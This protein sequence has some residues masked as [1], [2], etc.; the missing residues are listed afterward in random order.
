MV[1]LINNEENAAEGYDVETDD[2]E[3]AAKGVSNLFDEI[4]SRI[5][6][7]DQKRYVFLSYI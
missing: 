1:A 4:D 5:Y 7:A 2:L 3:A 6:E